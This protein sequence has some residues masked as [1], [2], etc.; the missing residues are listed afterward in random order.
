M[1]ALHICAMHG[2]PA[3]ARLLIAAKADVSLP[4]LSKGNTA[5]HLSA[6]QYKDD[7]VGEVSSAALQ[8]TLLTYLS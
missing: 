5:L 2:S 6:T 4:E 3:V 8:R 1:A 7:S